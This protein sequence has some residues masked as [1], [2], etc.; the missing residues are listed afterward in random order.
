MPSAAPEK[1]T[2]APEAVGRERGAR[3]TNAPFEPRHPGRIAPGGKGRK[4]ILTPKPRESDVARVAR[5]E[6]ERRHEELFPK[7]RPDVKKD[8]P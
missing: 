1:K 3:A 8:D 2:C 4:R 6:A 7:G 5:R